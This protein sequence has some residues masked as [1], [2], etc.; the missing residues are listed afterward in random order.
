MNPDS[1]FNAKQ[2]TDLIDVPAT[3]CYCIKRIVR[4]RALDFILL[5][6]YHPIAFQKY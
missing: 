5:N 6:G 2:Y 1:P 3:E 4:V